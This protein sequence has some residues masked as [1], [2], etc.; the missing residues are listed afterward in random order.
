MPEENS[1]AGGCGEEGSKTLPILHGQLKL[2][3]TWRS[4]LPARA[5]LGPVVQFASRHSVSKQ[6]AQFCGVSLH[7]RPVPQRR[8]GHVSPRRDSAAHKGR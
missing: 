3:E 5:L 1:R 4:R 7:Q 2:K 6:E 8:A